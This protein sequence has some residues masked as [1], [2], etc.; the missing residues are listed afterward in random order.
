MFISVFVCVCVCVCVCV[1]VCTCEH[2][3]YTGEV[4]MTY[5]EKSEDNVLESGLPFHLSVSS[6]D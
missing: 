4:T 2:G 6:G 3:V 5:M 1:H